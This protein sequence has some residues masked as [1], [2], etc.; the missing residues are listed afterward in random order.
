MHHQGAPRPPPQ[1]GGGGGGE[2]PGNVAGGGGPAAPPG[3]T[4]GGKGGSPAPPPPAEPPPPRAAS[5]PAETLIAA[6]AKPET[7]VT[8]ERPAKDEEGAPAAQRE[9]DLATPEPKAVPAEA[10]PAAERVE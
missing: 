10:P 4:R 2:N 5:K 7:F 9:T 3:G 8:A 6:N 1:G